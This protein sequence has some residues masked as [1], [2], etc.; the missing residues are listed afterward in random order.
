V[1]GLI[2]STLNAYYVFLKFSKLWQLQHSTGATQHS[3]GATQHSTGAA[4]H[5]TGA[6][7]HSTGATQ[8][9]TRHPAP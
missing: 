5:S 3:T 6:T 4:Q 1:P 9:G 2:I 7:K 8:R